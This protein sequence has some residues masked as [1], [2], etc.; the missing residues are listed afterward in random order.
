MRLHKLVMFC[1]AGTFPPVC[2]ATISKSTTG[3]YY[4]RSRRCQWQ[5]R[6]FF[7]LHHC[8]GLLGGTMQLGHYIYRN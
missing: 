1:T 4:Q 2:T 8:A 5:T 6:L 7:M 3:M